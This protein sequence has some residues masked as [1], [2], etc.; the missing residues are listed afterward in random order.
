MLG[1]WMTNYH[2]SFQCMLF[3]YIIFVNYIVK[4]LCYY[5]LI[6]TRGNDFPLL[7]LISF[8]Y[9]PPPS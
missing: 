8:E 1:D 3:T 2:A 5:L 6:C 4:Y 7:S 9:T